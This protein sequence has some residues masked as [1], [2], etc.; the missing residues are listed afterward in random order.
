[1]NVT[2]EEKRGHEFMPSSEP[3]WATSLKQ[4]RSETERTKEKKGATQEE[5]RGCGQQRR[6]VVITIQQKTKRLKESTSDRW[7]QSDKVCVCSL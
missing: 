1:M 3:C 5:L 4:H 2:K 6:R 7:I